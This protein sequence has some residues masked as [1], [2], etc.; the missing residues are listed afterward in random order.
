MPEIKL[1]RGIESKLPI[2]A[3]GEPGFTTDKGN[4]YIGG[5]L[6]NIRYAKKS[7][8]DELSSDVITLE[9]HLNNKATKEELNATNEHLAERAS[10]IK[11]VKVRPSGTSAQETLP[12]LISF[13]DD[14]GST[15]VYNNLLPIFEAKG[16]KFTTGIITDFI[17]TTGTYSGSPLTYMTALQIK[18]LYDKGHEI[19]SHSKTHRQMATIPASELESECLDSLN[20]IKEITGE[21]PATFIYPGGSENEAV[22]QE[23]RKHY[24][25]ARNSLQGYNRPPIETFRNVTYFID[26]PVADLTYCKARVDNIVAQ[27]GWL[28]FSTHV[29]FPQ[30]DTTKLQ[31]LSDLIDYIHTKGVQ[32]VTYKEGHKVYKNL[33]DVGNRK[34][35]PYFLIG[36][37][38]KVQTTHDFKD[39][40]FISKT[41]ISSSTKPSGFQLSK[42]T[43]TFFDNSDPLQFPETKAGSLT[44]VHPSGEFYWGYQEWRPLYSNRVYRRVATAGD[45]WTAWSAAD[46]MASFYQEVIGVSVTAT[47]PA[48]GFYDHEIT[49]SGVNNATDYAIVNK[50]SG[51]LTNLVITAF[52]S[53]NANTV[54]IRFQNLTASAVNLTGNIFNVGVIR[55]I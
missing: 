13:V 50:T 4:L 15:Q 7:E 18:E 32:I 43:V 22:T 45:A 48:S 5:S 37:D 52:V 31:M 38:G 1:R 27:G 51:A 6:G 23:V 11:E 9:S 28:V 36:A 25:C 54:T 14:D 26:D 20:V 49:V 34:S 33:L 21:V 12:P 39:Y 29:F 19:A 41:G 2:L 35:L 53:H 10:E 55:K 40:K 16:E 17:G 30:W 24:E 44:T 46:K 42:A 3:E 47:V 8:L